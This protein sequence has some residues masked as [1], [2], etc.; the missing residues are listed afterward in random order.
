[1]R[2]ILLFFSSFIMSSD[3]EDLLMLNKRFSAD[4]IISDSDLVVSK[5]YL[6]YMEGDFIYSI[7]HPSKQVLV[8]LEGILYVQD[9]DFKQVM[10]YSDD[11]SFIIKKLLLNSYKYDE[12]SCSSKCYRLNVNDERVTDAIIIF[13]NDHLYE[14]SISDF[15]N[16]IFLVK[17]ENFVHE[18]TNIIY[19][20]P[21]G[22]E[23]IAND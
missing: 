9:D 2:F 20:P 14:M 21:D 1:M 6:S 15:Q 7:N 18:S 4:I 22:Y 12:L 5:G 8:G 23:I 16:S 11:D 10:S 3:F 13:K 17:F 19:M